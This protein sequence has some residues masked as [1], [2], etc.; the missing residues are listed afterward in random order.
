[1]A[2]LLPERQADYI[3]RPTV[4]IT[5]L[6][7]VRLTDYPILQLRRLAGSVSVF[8]DQIQMLPI[9][10]LLTLQPTSDSL[11]QQTADLTG[12]MQIQTEVFRADFQLSA[13]ISET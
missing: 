11:K 5:G 13:G 2:A 8:P 9:R 4:E 10:Y 6:L 1:M 7:W 3:N 12:Q